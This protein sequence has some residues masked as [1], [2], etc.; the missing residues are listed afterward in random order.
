MPF[1]DVPEFMAR[2]RQRNAM[3]AL[4]LEI[5]ILTAA[6]TSEVLGARWNEIDFKQS[7]WTVPA[8]RMKGDARTAYRCR[9]GPWRSSKSSIGPG[10]ASTFSRDNGRARH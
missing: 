2:L 7:I 5:T 6:R 8:A 10:P 1:A 3:A 4:A 9:A